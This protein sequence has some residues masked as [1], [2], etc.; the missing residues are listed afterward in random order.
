M[1]DRLR[2]S[3]L[4]TFWPRIFWLTNGSS[5]VMSYSVMYTTSSWVRFYFILKNSLWTAS[6]F[7]EGEYDPRLSCM[8]STCYLWSYTHIPS[9]YLF[10]LGHHIWSDYWYSWINIYHV[11]AFY[12]LPLFSF[13]I[14]V[15][16]SFSVL[17]DFY[18]AF[19]RCYFL[20]S[21]SISV[22]LF[23][24]ISGFLEFAIYIYN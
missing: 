20:S 13:P 17:C 16:Y 4:L 5:H 12:L 14:S 18:C 9:L 3:G 10:N 8:L 24:K 2:N 15:F 23:K 7:L 22:T 21:L 19:A 1:V 11:S 6:V